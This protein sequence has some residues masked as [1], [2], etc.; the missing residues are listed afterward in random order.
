MKEISKEAFAHDLE[1][2]RFI[3]RFEPANHPRRE[4]YRAFLHGLRIKILLMCGYGVVIV[5]RCRSGKTY[6]LE[7]ALPGRVFGPD[8]AAVL[9][10]KLGCFNIGSAPKGMFAVDEPTYFKP[11]DLHSCFPALRKRKV[12]FA[13]QALTHL[14][15]L[16]LEEL[17]A[18]RLKI[19]YLGSR[20]EFLHERARVG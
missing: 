4:A 6:L 15:R 7:R 12:V 5:G 18:Q 11:S 8:R 9:A 14:T 17:F 2:I 19:V 20:E 3:P 13:V 16:K 1:N 10:G